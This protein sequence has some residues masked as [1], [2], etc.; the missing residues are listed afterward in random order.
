VELDIEGVHW[1]SI[2]FEDAVS[3]HVLNA[4]AHLGLD[5]RRNTSYP[6]AL[7][8]ITGF[9]ESALARAQEVV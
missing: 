4:L 2:A 9:P 1:E 6:A 3:Q 7:K 8:R 5:S